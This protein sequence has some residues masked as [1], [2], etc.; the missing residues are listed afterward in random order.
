MSTHHVYTQIYNKLVQTGCKPVS[1]I[2]LAAL[3]SDSLRLISKESNNNYIDVEDMI[4]S[5][6]YHDAIINKDIYD[7][8]SKHPYKGIQNRSDKKVQF[9]TA[10]LPLHLR[11]ILFTFLT[12]LRASAST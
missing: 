12:D 8:S 6:I 10:C 3:I 1:D 11:Q 7:G 9:D 5:L 4:Y 2:E